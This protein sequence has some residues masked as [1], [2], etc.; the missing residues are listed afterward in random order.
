MRGETSLASDREIR[1]KYAPMLKSRGKDALRVATEL[2]AFVNLLD[3]N[4]TLERALTDPSRPADDKQQV[5]D[6]ILGGRADPLTVDILHDLAALQ[7]SRIAH[8]ANAAEDMS[9]DATAYYAD[10]RGITNQVAGELAQIHSALLGMPLVLFHLSDEYS[11]P[12][13]RVNLLK[14]LL[15]G[16][17]LH[18][19]TEQLALNA[20]E[21]LRGRRFPDTVMWLVDRFSEHMDQVMVTVT[22]AIPMSDEQSSNIQAVYGRKLGK[23]VHI[24]SVV[25][26][27]VLGGMKVQYGSVSAD[28][29][30]VTQLKHLQRLMATAG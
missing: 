21:D 1:D 3:A 8:I 27:S 12:Q 30:V 6:L 29:T 23:A 28:G 13:A 10:A 14:S 18:P 9:V 16:Q 24:N 5:I 26:P 15:D 7:W 11:K 22:T 20:T 4:K 17:H 19:V 2:Y 25:D